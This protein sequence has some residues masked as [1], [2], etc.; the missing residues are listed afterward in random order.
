MNIEPLAPASWNELIVTPQHKQ[1]L[2]YEFLED[3]SLSSEE[4]GLLISQRVPKT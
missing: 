4:K 3:F 2:Q 1:G